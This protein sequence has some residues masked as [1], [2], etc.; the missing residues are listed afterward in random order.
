MRIRF[1]VTGGAG[2]G[3][4]HV[5]RTAVLAGEARERGYD[6]RVALRGD[7][8]ARTALSVELPDTTPCCWPTGDDVSANEHLVIDSPESIGDVIAAARD[9]GARTVVIDRLD[10]L[11]DADATVLPIVHG[12]ALPHPR[13]FQGP[14]YVLTAPIVRAHAGAPYPG[15]RRVALITFG[16][17]DPA[18]LTLPVTRV[19]LDTGVDF[20]TH[21]VIGPAFAEADALAKRLT[22]LGA[23]VH[24]GLTRA[25]VVGLMVRSRFALTGFG[26][27]LYDLAVIG[28]PAV[29]WTHRASDLADAGRLETRG[30]G[31]CAG[32]GDA[33]DDT[34]ARSAIA[35]TVLDAAW[36]ERASA[37][38]RQLVG[39]GDGARNVLDLVARL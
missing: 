18:G 36:R 22:A 5:M 34:R 2:W 35:R 1:L 19:L 31:A 3:L 21:V 38:A 33:F 37:S 6:V 8:A 7:A 30:L 10:H 24:R 12:P 28:T 39:A 14:A 4:G 32:S 16:G 25:D 29:Y 23:R 11:D 17:A 20:E 27:S 9:A 15:D 26:T 13:L